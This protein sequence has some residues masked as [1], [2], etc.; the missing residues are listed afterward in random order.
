M[1]DPL[2]IMDTIHTCGV[3]LDDDISIINMKTMRCGHMICCDCYDKLRANT[4]PFC[5]V[6][7]KH[8]FFTESRMFQHLFMDTLANIIQSSSQNVLPQKWRHPKFLSKIVDLENETISE[9]YKDDFDLLY[10][11][12]YDLTKKKEQLLSLNITVRTRC[13]CGSRSHSRITNHSCPLN[14]RRYSTMLS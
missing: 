7:Y 1:I 6:E 11:M 3:C 2:D 9:D 13:R 4:C 10:D 8:K 12:A 14:P 5:R